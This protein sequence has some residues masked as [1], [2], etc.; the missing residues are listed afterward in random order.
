MVKKLSILFI[1]LLALGLFVACGGND[2][3]DSGTQQQEPA[4]EETTLGDIVEDLFT[5]DEEDEE[6][7][8]TNNIKAILDANC[9][10]CHATS[11]R[12]DDRNGAPSKI[13]LDTYEA[14]T[15]KNSS[16]G[17]DVAASANAAIKSGQMPPGGALSATVKQLFQD[18][19]SEGTPE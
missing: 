17:L 5:D 1:L 18:W 4:E 10:S 19:I 2:D 6:I 14:A 11:K 13:N 9:I 12:D 3:D 15:E 7:T 16:S 8:Y